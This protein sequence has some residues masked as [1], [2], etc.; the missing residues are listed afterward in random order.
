[1][2]CEIIAELSFRMTDGNA[3]INL[4]EDSEYNESTVELISVDDEED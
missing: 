1:M 2:N 3:D 4:N